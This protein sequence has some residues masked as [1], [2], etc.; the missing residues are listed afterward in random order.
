M[1]KIIKRVKP[2]KNAKPMSKKAAI[3]FNKGIAKQIKP[4]PKRKK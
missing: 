2:K 3:R 4:L 1:V